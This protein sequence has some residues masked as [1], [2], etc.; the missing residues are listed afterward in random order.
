MRSCARILLLASMFMAAAATASL[1]AAPDGV[2]PEVSRALAD[3]GFAGRRADGTIAVWVWFTDKGLASGELA[4]ALAQAERELGDRARQRRAKM[5][6]AAG[7]SGLSVGL[8]DQTD[9]AVSAAHVQAVEATGAKL[10]RV[11]RWLN[12]ASFDVAPG[13][14]AALAAL[15]HVRRVTLVRRS[16]ELPAM[17]APDLGAPAP[18]ANAS[19]W[20]LDYGGSLEDLEQ[21]N[22]PAVHETGIHGQGVIIGMLDSGFRTTHECLSPLPVLAR[23]DFVNNDGVVENQ[24]GDPSDQDDHG[25][26]TMSTIAGY[27]PGSHVGPAWGATLVLAKTEDVSQEV[28]AEEDNW[29]AGIEWLDIY[30]V[31]VVSSS[32]G[33]LD[34]F[35]FADMDGNTAACTIAADLAV[36]KGIVVCNSAG[37]ERDTSWD[38]IIAPADGDSVIAAG[39]VT[40]TGTLSYFSSPGPSADGRI[41]PDVCALGSSN[42]VASTGTIAGYTT[43]SGTSFSCPLTAGVAALVLSRVPSLTPMQVREAMRATADRAGA[44]NNDFG[45]G[46]LDA[47]AAVY[48]FGPAL[49]HESLGDTEVTDAAYQVGATITSRTPL[50]YEEVLVHW[51]ADGGAWQQDWLINEFGDTFIGYIQPQPAGTMVD[52]Y[53]SAADIGGIGAT[54]PLD[55]PGAFFSFRVGPDLTPPVV[56]HVPL[57]SQPLATWPPQIRATVTDNLGVASVDVAYSIN[58]V[59]RDD[60]ALLAQGADLWSAPFPVPAGELAVGDVVSYTINVSD[61][62]LVPNLVAD[63]PHVLTIIDALGVALVIDDTGAKSGGAV[64]ADVKY[65]L[66]KRPVAPSAGKA[67]PADLGRWLREAGYVTR[68]VDAAALTAADFDACQFAVLTSGANTAPVASASLRSLLEAWTA[69]GGKLIVEGG[70]T[71]YDA[72][73]SPGYP[74]FAGGVL[75]AAT[76]RADNAGTLEVL[77]PTHPVATTPHA[78]PAVLALAYDGY[79]DQDALSPAAGAAVVYETSGYAGAAGVLAWDDDAVPSAGQIVVLACN[80]GALAD[81]TAARHL[82]ENAAAWLLASQGAATA[83]ISGTVT[84]LNGDVVTGLDGATISAGPGHVVNSGP[85]GHYLIDG[86][87]AG[88]YTVT[89]SAPGM[90]TEIVTVQ[91]AEGEAGSAGATLRYTLTNTFTQ[92]TPASI[93]DED[94]AGVTSVLY[95]PASAPITAVT[96]G[97][98]LTHTWI[99]DLV[100]ELTSP[101]GT[102]VRLH[103]RSGSSAD[104]IAGT[105]GTTLVVDGPGALSDF[106]G[107]NMGG[108]WTMFIADL[109][110]S[111]VGTLNSW[112]LNITHAAVISG[113]PD[114]P[115][116]AYRLLPNRPNPF[117][118]RTEIRFELARAGTP[119]LAIFDLRGHK[120]RDLL[121]DQPFAAGVHAV[122][123]DG[124]D[125]AGHDVAS[126]L[127]ISRIEADGQRLE[128]KMTLLR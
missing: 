17:T 19:Q 45:W 104:N 70:E 100:V 29:V 89:F 128:R 90:T 91:L 119:R 113:A 79:G 103:N 55:A 122:P 72:I 27:A 8:V 101:A 81:T 84:Q 15:P 22:V 10:R 62:A 67:A 21:I 96:V 93:P 83:S 13:Q 69:A 110:G 118:P 61:A 31:D 6:A 109:A 23:W 33:Y 46:I 77:Q 106:V 35:T 111:D 98:S 65:D 94:P 11:S 121:S 57:G 115:A 126:G 76:W 53:L 25:T 86:L 20:S 56:A 2:M 39:A 58:G 26:K 71:G 114:T 36:G 120:V 34:W 80:V 59:P 40:S 85:G 37:N 73:S 68:V 108:N 99:G 88:T 5:Q 64:I 30:G 48:Y 105:Y 124:R 16:R 32:L 18:R 4:G 42:H 52:Y 123:W 78:L 95:V 7:K 112:S 44:P 49:G 66:D 43:A 87:Y 75:H 9:L 74:T 107:E 24:P 47:Y 116:A 117:N 54:L 12:A 28:P 125:D 50:R 92:G 60:F 3:P 14:V 82:V 41:K 102:T 1:S 38:H 127:Y 97:V 63:G 51:R